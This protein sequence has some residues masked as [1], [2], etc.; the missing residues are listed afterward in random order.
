MPQKAHLNGSTK[1]PKKGFFLTP[2]IFIFPILQ[3]WTLPKGPSRT[4]NTAESKF[5]TE[6]KFSTA[7]TKTVRRVLRNTLFF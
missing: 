5:S 7:I 4:K 1:D 6:T 2:T 3:I